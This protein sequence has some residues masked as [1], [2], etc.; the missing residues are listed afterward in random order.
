MRPSSVS[1]IDLDGDEDFDLVTANYHPGKVSIL[2]NN[3]DG[4]LQTAVDYDAGDGPISVFSI[5]LDGDGDDDLATANQMSNN[6]SILINIGDGSFQ[7]AAN[8]DTGDGPSSVFAIDL[9]G[10]GDNDLATANLV[11]DNVSILLNNGYGAFQKTVDDYDSGDSP[12]SIFSID[13]NGDGSHDLVTANQGSDNVSVLLNNGDGLFPCGDWETVGGDTHTWKMYI[14]PEDNC[15]WYLTADNGLHITRDC[16][17]NWEH[18]LSGDGWSFTRGLA[19]DPNEPNN[20]FVWRPPGI[21]RSDDKG[22][23]WLLVDTF[24]VIMS[25]LISPIDGACFATGRLDTFTPGIYRSYDIGQTWEF[26]SYNIVTPNLITWDI[27][28][29]PINGILYACT[30]LGDH[31]QP[32]NPPFYRSM[33]RGETWEDISGILPW[34]VVRIQVH[35]ETQDVYA[36]TEGAGLYRSSDFGNTWQYLN[37]YFL[38]EL[39][40]D[41]NNPCIFYGGNHTH[42]NRGGGAYLS[43]DTGNTWEEIGLRGKIVGSLVLNNSSTKLHASCY[44]SGIYYRELDSIDTACEPCCGQYIGG[45]TGNANCSEDGKL[46]LSDITA[47]IDHVYISKL[48]L[49][50]QAAGNVNGSPGCKITLSDITGLIDAIYIS[51]AQPALCMAECEQ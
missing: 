12:L 27:E 24:E 4:T 22:A 44:S 35:P 36:L 11:S 31:P 8:Y 20:V 34:H 1:A 40:I 3:G 30:E 26:F 51:K 50:C 5:D 17:R 16:G 7:P 6:V 18:H 21:F 13:L 23:S 43:R 45:I 9:D 38:L 15:Q 28:E 47:L 14:D 49:C 33:D 48:P 25:M 41:K 39:L 19:V 46:T 10:D 42:G 29:D 2:M 37:N 32:Y